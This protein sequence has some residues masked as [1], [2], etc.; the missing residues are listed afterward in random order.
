MGWL[1]GPLILVVF[2]YITY[3]TATLLSDYYRSPAG[4]RNYTYIGVVKA[5]LGNNPSPP[6]WSA[7]LMLLQAHMYLYMHTSCAHV[8]GWG[9][10]YSIF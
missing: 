10:G 5:Y 9:V 2:A 7:L 3:Y 1:L 4:R 8:C 6:N